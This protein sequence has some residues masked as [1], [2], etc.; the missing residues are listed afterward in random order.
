MRNRNTNTILR[1]VSI[2]FLTAALVLSIISLI[3]YSRQRNNYPAGMSIAGVSVGGLTPTEASQRLLEVYTPPI[4]AFYNEAVIHIDPG[5]VGFQPDIET[6]LAAADL[7]RTG[8]P[9]WGGFWNYL[10]NRN[11]PEI[12]IPLSA[13]ISDE[14]LREY[15]QNE[16]AAR[17][18]LPPAPAQPI[19][20]GT[21]FL[22]APRQTSTLT[23]PFTYQRRIECPNK[24][25][26]FAHF[27]TQFRRKT[28]HD[29]LTILLKQIVT[30]SDFDGLIGFYMMDLKRGRKSILQ[31]ITSEEVRWAD[32]AFTASST[33]KVAIVA[34]YLINRGSNLVTTTN[35]VISRVLGKSD[36]SATDLVLERIEQ[37][38][39]PL[40]VTRI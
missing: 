14:R 28:H 10:W 36:N 13:T 21:S 5:V 32:I 30:V 16:I 24:P 29:N 23:V 6:M 40:I 4:E 35:R 38:A 12:T 31:L 18:D 11:P 15:L 37:N 1:G 3:R 34:S 20:G 25:F 7:S 17:Y 26:R 22:P 33:I 19:P 27:H 9:F 39:G 2:L 8:G